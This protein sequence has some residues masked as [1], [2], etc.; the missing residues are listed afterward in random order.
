MARSS[1]LALKLPNPPNTPYEPTR[2][3]EASRA[4]TCSLRKGIAAN[5]SPHEYECMNRLMLT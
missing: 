4:G 3:Q 2:V 5:M 1:K